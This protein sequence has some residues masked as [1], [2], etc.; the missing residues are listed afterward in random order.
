[1]LARR[2]RLIPHVSGKT[3]ALARIPGKNAAKRRASA[4]GLSR[5]VTF[6][7]ARAKSRR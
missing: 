5:D 3:Q 7:G 6:A 1:M 2:G 4:R